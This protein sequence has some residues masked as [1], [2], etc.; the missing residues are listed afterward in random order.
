MVKKSRDLI[1][2]LL[3]SEPKIKQIYILLSVDLSRED[4]TLGSMS[5]KKYV[6]ELNTTGKFFTKSGGWSYSLTEMTTLA[7]S[8][9]AD[10]KNS[11]T[12]LEKSRNLKGKLWIRE[13]QTKYSIVR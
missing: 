11:K 6:L 10:A 2:F 13:I 3:T 4:G 8:N 12:F 1:T 5:K 9:K 7:Y